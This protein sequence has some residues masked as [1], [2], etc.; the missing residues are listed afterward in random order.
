MVGIEKGEEGITFGL[1]DVDTNLGEAGEELTGVDL[2]VAIHGVEVSEDSSETS[3]GLGT[4]SLELSSEF[5][6]N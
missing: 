6:E 3:D 2:S 1:G 4:S 5:V